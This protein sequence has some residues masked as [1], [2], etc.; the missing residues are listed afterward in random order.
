MNCAIEDQ[1]MALIIIGPAVVLPDIEIVDWRTEEE[2]ANVVERFGIGV[3]NPI[4]PPSCRPLHERNMQAVIMRICEWRILA[5]VAISRVRAAS[6]VVPG[7]NAG[8]YVLVHGNDQ[9]QS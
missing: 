7:G 8:R 1:P 3:R 5:V 9:V 2:F 4:M 6:V